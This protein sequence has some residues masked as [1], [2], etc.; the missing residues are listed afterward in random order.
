[1]NTEIGTDL[2]KALDFIQSGKTVAVPT[3]TVYGL[4]ADANNEEAVLSIFEA[5]GR[6]TSNPLILHFD[7][8][9]TALPYTTSF[10]AIFETLYH[11]FC[12]G[13]LTFVVPKSS[14]VSSLI[15]GGQETVALRFPKHPLLQ[16]L[17]QKL[18]LPLAA[19]SANLYG[20]LSPTSAVHVQTQLAG[21]IPYILDGG[22]CEEGLESTIIGLIDEQVVVY[23]YGSIT[24]EALSALLGYLPEAKTNADGTVLT[25][26]MV[27]HHYATQT[28]L[29]LGAKPARE[30]DLALQ[31]SLQQDPN[32]GGPQ[33]ALSTNGSMI[34]AA[35]NLYATLHQADALGLQKIY[36]APF[37]NEGL[38]RAMNDRLMRA[39]AKFSQV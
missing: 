28:P 9:Q 22:N 21:R 15:T 1:M 5:K 18:G 4:A 20:Q 27:K 11:T 14:L 31:I 12:P 26:G 32:I 34:E 37:P 3:E 8:L 2:F 23:R 29:F 6:P 24:P 36:V 38:G 35:R 17:L 7:T 19:P 25:S 39:A 16:H 30:Q 10:P 13:P 33:L